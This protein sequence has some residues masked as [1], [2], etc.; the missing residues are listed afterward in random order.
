MVRA[1]RERLAAAAADARASA[2]A[3]RRD[4]GERASLGPR[5][6]WSAVSWARARREASRCARPAPPGALAPWSPCF[7]MARVLGS[8]A[9][10]RRGKRKCGGSAKNQEKTRGASSQ[11]PE[12]ERP[13]REIKK[14]ESRVTRAHAAAHYSRAFFC[15]GAKQPVRVL[16]VHTSPS[17]AREVDAVEDDARIA[18]WSARHCDLWPPFRPRLWVRFFFVS[19]FFGHSGRPFLRGHGPRARALLFFFIASVIPA[20]AGIR[21]RDRQRIARRVPLC[22]REST[23][24]RAERKRAGPQRVKSTGFRL[25]ASASLPIAVGPLPRTHARRKKGRKRRGKAR[26]ADAIR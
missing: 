10:R 23:R 13:A 24:R 17:R 11:M 1:G 3:A 18:A 6:T 21:M 22:R 25:I 19:F 14:E 12:R 5:L 20:A 4:A 16:A 26:K 2:P 7:F 8:T 9:R 15:R